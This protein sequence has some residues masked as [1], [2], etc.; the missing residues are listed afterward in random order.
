MIE[1]VA[2]TMLTASGTPAM[3]EEPPL[4]V[5]GAPFIIRSS[6]ERVMPEIQP[7][8]LASGVLYQVSPS[9]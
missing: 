5:I 3:G 1:P 2:W 4:I 7:L 8:A 6:S 9:A